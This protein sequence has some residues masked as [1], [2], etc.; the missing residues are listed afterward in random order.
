MSQRWKIFLIFAA[1]VLMFTGIGVMTMRYQPQRE[2]E[3]YKNVLRAKGEKLEIAEVL[4]PVVPPDQNGADTVL[5]AF[6]LLTSDDNYTNLPPMMPM[7]AFGKAIVGWAQPDVRD[8]NYTNTWEN[9]MAAAEA[10]R[11]ATEL[12]KQ[13]MAY[14]AI[15]FRLDYSKGAGM[16]LPYLASLKR[17]AQKL[18]AAAMCDLHHGDCASATTNLCALLALVQG[19]HDER[20]LVSQLVRM[21]MAS[22]AASSSWELLQSTNLTGSQLA[23]LQKSWER[24]EFIEAAGNSMEMERAM[25][26]TNI[27]KMRASNAEFQRVFHSYGPGSSSPSGGWSGS[28]SWLEDFGNFDRNGWDKTK[29]VGAT[30]LWR[31]SWSY[32]D[33]LRTLQGEQIALETMRTVKTNQF[34][35]PAYTNMVNRFYALGF[36]N[37]PDDWLTKLDIRDFRQI[38]S[39][40]LVGLSAMVRKTMAA[41]TCKRVVITAIVLKRFQLERGHFPERLSELAPEFLESVPLDPV[42]GQPLRYHLNADGT[43]TLYSVGLNGKDD[44]G[45]PSPGK[46]VRSSFFYWQNP[47]A[48]DRVWPQ[49]ATPEEVQFYYEHPPK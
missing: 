34:F 6:A 18:S 36:T 12:L 4:P 29:M 13:A 48:L 23:V 27:I 44:G 49:P 16:L 38:F 20:T 19:T 17:S 46:G 32:S 30:F 37:T 35:N 9:V 21:A 26:E 39:G 8:Y 1:G 31:T 11:P 33:E 28:G 2:V 42:D 41:E 40:D 15:D 43:F 24:L 10:N 5:T 3:A 25:T 14:P 47:D 7:V 45:D 22:I